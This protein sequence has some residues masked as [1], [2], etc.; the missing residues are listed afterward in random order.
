MYF[1]ILIHSN[2]YAW[3]IFWK[4]FVYNLSSYRNKRITVIELRNESERNVI[5]F[6]QLR[7]SKISL[8]KKFQTIEIYL[9]LTLFLKSKYI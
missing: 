5:S 1:L 9:F 6:S 3:K 4:C 8:V 7:K 2:F